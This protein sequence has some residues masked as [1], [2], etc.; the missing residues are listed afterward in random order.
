MLNVRLLAG[1]G[2]APRAVGEALLLVVR[3]VFRNEEDAW[4]SSLVSAGSSHFGRPTIKTTRSARDGTVL[5]RVLLAPTDGLAIV[6]GWFQ[7]HPAAALRQVLLQQ[8]GGRGLLVYDPDQLRLLL[9]FSETIA[10]WATSVWHGCMHTLRHVESSHAQ[11]QR[12]T[13]DHLHAWRLLRVV[14]NFHQRVKTQLNR[15]A[16]CSELKRKV[17]LKRRALLLLLCQRRFGPLPREVLQLILD[18]A[19][20]PGLPPRAGR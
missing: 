19:Y 13:A 10:R 8:D 4:Y 14:A 11:R 5:R 16:V 12:A 20:G 3:H 15:L 17:E 9:L 6:I 18:K 1:P 7:S 2:G